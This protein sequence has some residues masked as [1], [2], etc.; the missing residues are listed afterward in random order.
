[1]GKLEEIRN[2][3]PFMVRTMKSIGIHSREAL[4]AADYREIK[5]SLLQMGIKPHLNIFYSI[6]MGL[7]NR[8]WNDITSDEKKEIRALL[9]SP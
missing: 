9:N 5:N 3:G 2:F 7:Q 6:E 8:R 1:M 4:M